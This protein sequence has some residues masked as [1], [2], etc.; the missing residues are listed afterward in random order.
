MD[1]FQWMSLALVGDRKGI[2]PQNLCTN[3]PSWSVMESTFLHSSSFIAVLSLSEDT[4]PLD[5]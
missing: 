2:R 1:E 5:T 4:V 3:Y